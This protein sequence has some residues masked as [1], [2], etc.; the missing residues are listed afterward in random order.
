MTPL[1]QATFD[2][3]LMMILLQFIQKHNIRA[4]TYLVGTVEQFYQRYKKILVDYEKGT[5]TNIK[6]FAIKKEIEEGLPNWK[7]LKTWC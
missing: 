7:K 4:D 6:S 3:K 1:V 5:V 2:P